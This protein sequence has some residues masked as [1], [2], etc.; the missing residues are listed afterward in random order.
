MCSPGLL[1]FS[2]DPSNV[3]HGGVS[4]VHSTESDKEEKQLEARGWGEGRE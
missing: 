1:S 4:L 2:A 3:I